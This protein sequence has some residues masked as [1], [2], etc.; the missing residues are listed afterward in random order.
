MRSQMDVGAAFTQLQSSRQ[1]ANKTKAPEMKD[2]RLSLQDEGPVPMDI[3]EKMKQDREAEAKRVTASAS[4]SAS[5][6][7]YQR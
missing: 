5:A 3:F 4:A 6:W 7:R 1:N 2:F